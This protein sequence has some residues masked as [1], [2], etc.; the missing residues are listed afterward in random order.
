M[1]KIRA[2]TCII[3][4]Q[5]AGADVALSRVSLANF[6]RQ[7]ILLPYATWLYHLA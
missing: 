3:A 2:V 7:L 5:T 1:R 6:G 4:R